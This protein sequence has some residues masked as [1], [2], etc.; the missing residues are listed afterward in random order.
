M[1]QR[2]FAGELDAA[3]AAVRA[4]VRVSRLLER[5]LEEL[6]LPHYRVLAALSTGE[7]LASRVAARLA[8]GRPAVSA[9][10]ASLAER[11]LLVR[12]DVAGDQRTVALRLTAAGW[13]TLARAD[14]AMSGEL[15]VL[16]AKTADPEGLFETIGLLNEAVSATYAERRAGHTG[17]KPGTAAAAASSTR[18]GPAE[19]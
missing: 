1:Q 5:S 18:G 8:L 4:L 12:V 9:A 19:P 6:S 3:A 10:V 15:R 2:E 17:I 14:A 16:A 7:E 13:E 11:G